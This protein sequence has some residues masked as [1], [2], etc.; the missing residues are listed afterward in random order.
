[1]PFD[2]MFLYNLAVW[3][4]ATGSFGPTV[5]AATLIGVAASLVVVG[6]LAVRSFKGK[7]G[8]S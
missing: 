4:A 1:M 6:V 5:Q 2:F 3:K 8:A 7:G